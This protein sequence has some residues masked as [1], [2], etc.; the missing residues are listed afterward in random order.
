MEPETP[1]RRGRPAGPPG[2]SLGDYLRKLRESR[3]LTVRDLAKL[4]GLPTT[5]ASYISQLEAGL[6][7]PNPELA[8][9]LAERLGDRQGIFRLWALTGR[10][11]DPHRSAL[12]LRQLSRLLSDPS[13]AHDPHFT[14]PGLARIEAARRSLLDRRQ[15]G[16][17]FLRDDAADAAEALERRDAE[18][19]IAMARAEN[20]D[21]GTDRGEFL[22]TH[23]ESAYLARRPESPRAL[24]IPIIPEGMD[25]DQ[26]RAFE[27]RQRGDWHG[28]SLRLEPDAA[29][30]LRLERPF[31]YRL[32]ERGVRRLASLLKAGDVAVITREIGPLA[33]HEVYAVRVGGRVEL[34]LVMWNGREL[35]LLP[36]EGESDFLVLPMPDEGAMSE[37]IVGHL[38]TVVR[39]SSAPWR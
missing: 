36:A 17:R 5:S 26:A 6:K 34:A 30:A 29:H 31:A 32:G 13:L 15:I 9:R 14:H 1:R 21:R 3:G 38:A 7:V 23:R 25:P 10:R 19:R 28:E 22:A 4:V 18:R 39:A 20:P 2:H 24:S 8:E 35:L 37:L 27:Q 12:A 33:P 11:A 16:A